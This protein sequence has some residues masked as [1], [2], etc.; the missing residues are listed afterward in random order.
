MNAYTCEKSYGNLLINC[1]QRTFA[2]KYNWLLFIAE[3][4]SKSNNPHKY[5][6]VRV[7]VFLS[8]EATDEISNQILMDIEF[9]ANL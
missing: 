5:A 4:Y 1:L 2:I 8:V 6:F 3:N 9:L 7:F